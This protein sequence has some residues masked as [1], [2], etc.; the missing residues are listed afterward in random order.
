MTSRVLVCR[1]RYQSAPC[2]TSR[3]SG[4]NARAGLRNNRASSTVPGNGFDVSRSINVG[5]MSLGSYKSRRITLTV[6]MVTPNTPAP[7]AI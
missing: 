5:A 2:D 1:N 3:G 4:S 6:S 7:R